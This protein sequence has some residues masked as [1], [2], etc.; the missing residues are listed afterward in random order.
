[1]VIIYNVQDKKTKIYRTLSITWNNLGKR[2]VT[3]TQ[4]GLTPPPP[5]I[6]PLC[7]YPL[8][9][10]IPPFTLKNVNYQPL[11]AAHYVFVNF[12]FSFRSTGNLK[13]DFSSWTDRNTKQFRNT[14]IQTSFI[15]SKRSYVLSVVQFS[16]YF[17][18]NN[19]NFK[20]VAIK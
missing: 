1:M 10:S 8:I 7:H 11:E 13:V 15:R 6:P 2:N 14:F 17:Y 20:T 5:A 19:K 18:K 9:L 4:F 3:P 16:W 12:K